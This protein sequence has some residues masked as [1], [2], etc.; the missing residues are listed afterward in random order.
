MAILKTFEK[1]WQQVKIINRPFPKASKSVSIGFNSLTL[2]IP[3]R[4]KLTYLMNCLPHCLMEKRI[5]S[6]SSK[7]QKRNIFTAKNQLS[8]LI[9]SFLYS[10]S[11]DV[12]RAL[13]TFESHFNRV[14]GK[15]RRMQVVENN[16]SK[17]LLGKWTVRETNSVQTENRC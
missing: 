7:F 14:C 4:V 9:T 11:F 12:Q 10:Q 6:I 8:K 5:I 13:K 15:I 3:K 16:L 17:Q 1:M 2:C